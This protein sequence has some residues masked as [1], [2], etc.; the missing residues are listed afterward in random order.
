MLGRLFESAGRL[1]PGEAARLLPQA[2]IGG[3]MPW[4]IAIMVALTVIAAAAALALDNVAEN[5]RS[6]IAGGITVQVVE[7][8]PAERARQTQ[9]AL[10]FLETDPRVTEVHQVPQEELSQL[11]EPWL[12]AGAVDDDAM[13]TPSLIDAQLDG[14]VS[15]Q[16]LSSLRAEMAKVAPAAQID[17]QANWLG[18]VFDALRS[19]K[20]LALGLVALLALTA[21]AAVWL[22]AR[23]ALGSNRDTIEVI[24]HLGGTD[25]QIAAIF[26]RSVGI[27]AVIGGVAGLLLGLAAVMVLGAQ[28]AALGSGLVAGGGLSLGDWGLLLAVPVIALVLAMITARATVLTALRRKL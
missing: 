5:A 21:A 25:G 12:G 26:Q 27:D 17:A 19:L 24:H 1:M 2:R 10:A 3:P 4:V 23:T 18:P 9:A 15:A 11:L 22:A 14:E 6:E 13:A 16:M 8:A 20:L 7:G 28:F